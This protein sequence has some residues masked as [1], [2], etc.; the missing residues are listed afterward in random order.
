MVDWR[1]FVCTSA[2]LSSAMLL[3]ESETM[4]SHHMLSDALVLT[5][6]FC[7]RYFSSSSKQIMGWKKEHEQ[8]QNTS[9]T[10]K[11]TS[12]Q[13]SIKFNFYVKDIHLRILHSSK[14]A[15]PGN[16]VQESI[17]KG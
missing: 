15:A 14:E 2:H 6:V 16:I 5:S 4:C 13:H 7:T 12:C 17:F 8:L 11:L 1:V 10:N 9:A 3:L